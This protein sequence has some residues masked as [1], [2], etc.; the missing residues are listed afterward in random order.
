MLSEYMQAISTHYANSHC[1]YI[2]VTGTTQENIS[3]EVMELAKKRLGP[4]AQIT[5]QVYPALC[6]CVCVTVS[7]CRTFGG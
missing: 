7:S 6:V 5:F 2:D 1:E 3:T 4:D